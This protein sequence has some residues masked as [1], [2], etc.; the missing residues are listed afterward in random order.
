MDEGAK[1]DERALYA[2]AVGS[3]GVY[4]EIVHTLRVSVREARHVRTFSRY[5]SSA[6]GAGTGPKVTRLSGSTPS[7]TTK[8][9]E[10]ALSKGDTSGTE[11]PTGE[12]LTNVAWWVYCPEREKTRVGNVLLLR[13]Y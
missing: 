8:S 10:L 6:V 11:T 4:P 3:V 5:N 9:H 13:F 7:P 2:L 12:G 1:C